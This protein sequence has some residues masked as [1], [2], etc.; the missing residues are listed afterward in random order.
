MFAQG[1]KVRIIQGE[2]AGQTGVVQYE[3]FG[4]MRRLG[5]MYRVRVWSEQADP[6]GKPVRN[7]LRIV[8]IYEHQLQKNDP[9]PQ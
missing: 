6:F 8:W 7:H 2:H 3:G 1:E 5:N 9:C 4:P